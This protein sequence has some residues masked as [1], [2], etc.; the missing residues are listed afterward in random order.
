[1]E[2]S[3]EW[4]VKNKTAE[5]AAANYPNIRLLEL[6]RQPT[7]SPQPSFDASVAGARWQPCR[8]IRCVRFRRRPTFSDATSISKPASPSG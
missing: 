3:F 8:P 1:M 2:M 6:P 4:N 7:W 5:V